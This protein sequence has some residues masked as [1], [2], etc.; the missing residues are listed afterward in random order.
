MDD[1]QHYW[2]QTTIQVRRENPAGPGGPSSFPI[3]DLVG[4]D[5]ATVV[6]KCKRCGLVRRIT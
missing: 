5:A 2:A 3:Y 4:N 6:N 1:C